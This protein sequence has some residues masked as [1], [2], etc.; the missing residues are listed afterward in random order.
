MYRLTRRRLANRPLI[1][2]ALVAA[3]ALA[4][5]G[6][7]THAAARQ[8]AA[9]TDK[10]SVVSLPY[11]PVGIASDGS[12]LW[13]CGV[14]EMLAKS[15]DGG[16]TWV[17]KHVKVGGEVL[18]SVGLLGEKTVYA[19]GTSGV[20]L[21]SD[22]SGEKWKSSMSGSETILD[23]IFT[24]ASHGLLR[25][26][27]NVQFTTDGGAHWADVSVMKSDD[28]VKL[29]SNIYGIA[30]IDSSHYALLLNRTQGENIFLSTRDGGVTWKP[31]HVDNTYARELFAH[32]GRYWAFGGE[33]VDRKNRGGYSV[34]LA[35]YSTDGLQ[36]T[37]GTKSPKEFETCTSQGCVVYDG[38]IVDLY[39]ERPRFTIFPADGIVTAKWAVSKDSI[40]TIG[41]VLECAGTSPSD[42]LPA[43]SASQ[44]RSIT[45]GRENVSNP[46]PNCLICP[47]DQFS[48]DKKLLDQ[49][50]VTMFDANGPHETII[51]GL[52]AAL[53][54]HY[55]VASDG[56]VGGVIVRGA[57]RQDIQTPLIQQISAWVFN[58]P[59]ASRTPDDAEYVIRLI[60]R[61]SVDFPSDD[62]A[63]C[64]LTFP[65][66]RINSDS[67]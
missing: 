29:F 52:N 10:W 21:W 48:L 30:A 8:G 19:S 63:T 22:D 5:S 6:M 7:V 32:D 12:V 56:T 17:I 37:H 27:S 58:P 67:N 46:P 60:V 16:K 61:C 31:L 28:A 24:D 23:S 51:P 43:R 35:L 39:G 25:T 18:L 3:Q 66:Q 11:R 20:M 1:L 55:Q 13:V 9:P 50:P 36:W 42:D 65:Q 53:E 59:H 38:A 44:R 34:P 47:L 40:C 14:D 45:A 64:T 49:V 62:E 57:S 26:L 2:V 15:E 54:V 33:I 4:L 41:S